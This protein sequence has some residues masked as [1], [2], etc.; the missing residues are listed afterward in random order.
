MSEGLIDSSTFQF[1]NFTSDDDLAFY[2][3][4]PSLATFNAIFECLNAGSNGKNIRLVNHLIQEIVLN[5][6]GQKTRAW[7]RNP[8]LLAS[9][10]IMCPVLFSNKR[11]RDLVDIEPLFWHPSS[12]FPVGTALL[13]LLLDLTAFLKFLWNF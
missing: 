8:D 4:F 5:D 6:M 7:L 10:K 13:L 3:G 11:K 2:T 12:I 9:C 1:R